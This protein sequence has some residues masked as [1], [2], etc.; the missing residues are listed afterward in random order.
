MSDV[1]VEAHRKIS[2]D[3]L[4]YLVAYNALIAID[5]EPPQRIVKYLREALGNDSRLPDE[6]ID[7]PAGDMISVSVQ[8]VGDVEY[9]SG[10]IIKIADLPPG[11]VALRIYMS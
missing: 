3:D 4:E 5:T 8:G 2:E 9:G 11:A 7:M 1:Y 6:K 10:M